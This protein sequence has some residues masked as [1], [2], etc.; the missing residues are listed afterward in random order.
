MVRKNV[1]KKIVKE[2][3]IQRTCKSFS[4]FRKAFLAYISM[5]QN[6]QEPLNWNN[7]IENKFV[8]NNW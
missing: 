8:K 2:C 3:S 4:I 6:L 7:G 1:K 5:V